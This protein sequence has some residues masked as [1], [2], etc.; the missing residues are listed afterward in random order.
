MDK[1]VG[2]RDAAPRPAPGG[3]AAPPPRVPP[4]CRGDPPEAAVPL[5]LAPGAPV[6]RLDTAVPAVFRPAR[7]VDW[8]SPP[9][10]TATRWEQALSELRRDSPDRHPMH[11]P[12]QEVWRARY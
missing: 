12:W 3:L 11:P 10:V 6:A 5:L 8:R 1:A 7:M 9:R 2:R 4:S